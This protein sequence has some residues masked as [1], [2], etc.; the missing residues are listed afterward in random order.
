MKTE[1]NI[2]IAF[3]LN[4]G[5]SLF[6]ILGGMITGSVAILSDAVHDMGDAMTIGISYILEKKSKKKAND[7]YTYGY[8][9]YS[10]MGSLVTTIVLI[11]GSILI[12]ISAIHRIFNPI[13]IKYNGMIFI[14]IIGVVINFLAAYITKDGHS[15]NQKSVNLHMLEDVL[16]WIVVLIG[17]VVMKFTDITIID[18]LMSIGVAIFILYNAFINFREIIDLFLE[19]APKGMEKKKIKRELLKIDG[20][21]DVHHIHLWSLDGNKN[22]ATLHIKTNRKFSE[23]KKIIKKE[24]KNLGIVHSTLEFEEIDEPCPDELFKEIERK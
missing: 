9:R 5:F 6:E 18:P 8:V 17:A 2:L 4:L 20:V 1:R 16:G 7:V 19:K 3:I 24:L 13:I 10:V 15:L 12:T 22:Y 14:A 21:Y 23:M 11:V